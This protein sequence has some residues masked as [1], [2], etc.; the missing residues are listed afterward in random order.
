MTLSLD[1]TRDRRLDGASVADN[2]QGRDPVTQPS[3]APPPPSSTL[4]GRVRAMLARAQ[5]P[6]RWLWCAVAVGGGSIMAQRQG[7]ISEGMMRATVIGGVGLY[8]ASEVLDQVRKV[9]LNR[10]RLPWLRIALRSVGVAVVLWELIGHLVLRS[11]HG[12]GDGVVAFLM[13]VSLCAAGIMDLS[14]GLSRG[15]LQG[16]TAVRLASGVLGLLA[17]LASVTLV[18]QAPPATARWLGVVFLAALPLVLMGAVT[19]R[20]VALEDDRAEAALRG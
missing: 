6:G 15:T 14:R 11:S 7:W 8:T 1:R 13:I 20:M 4:G 17:L 18:D 16:W 9:R 12:S 3:G 19:A 2:A 5:V 10:G